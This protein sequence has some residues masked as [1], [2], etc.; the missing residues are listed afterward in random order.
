MKHLIFIVLIFGFIISSCE[1]RHKKVEIQE[2]VIDVNNPIELYFSDLVDTC[3]FITLD[4]EAIIGEIDWM[5][6]GENK[7][8]ILDASVSNSIYLFDFDGLLKTTIR[9]FGEGP[10]KYRI[11]R[12]LNLIE[13]ENVISI[14]DDATPKIMNYSL[15]GVL[16]SENL[17][18]EFGQFNGLI[19]DGEGF[20]AYSRLGSFENGDA[21]IYF[22]YDFSKPIYPIEKL[23][24]EGWE[25]D[26]GLQHSFYQSRN[27]KN[28]YFQVNT[29]SD[30]IEFNKE[31]KVSHSRFN[32][33]SRG[34]DYTK[35][36]I[37]PHELLSLSRAQ[38]FVYLGPN[39]V[40]GGNFMLL[41]LLDKGIGSLA[42]YDKKTGKAIKVSRLVNDL[43]L[44]MNF[45]GIPG[46]YTNQSGYLS[47]QMPFS[48]FDAVRGR[49]DFE[50]NSY[51]DIIQNIDSNDPESLVLMI[52]KLKENVDIS[53]D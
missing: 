15:D 8:A 28:H 37:K 51:Q 26:H 9:D 32:F 48:Q 42:F 34:L 46:A 4:A 25:K 53:F 20:W 52:Y 11:P 23:S 31:G 35:S 40:D 18:R 17:L 10:G 38:E 44:M 39:H 33:S 29:T 22:D 16:Q 14:Y 12:Y 30:L 21:L 7:I 2:V 1:Q 45:S 27:S 6:I 47:L 36:E 13:N 50:G 19:S 41:D 5:Q 43:S 3:Y 49:V 24:F